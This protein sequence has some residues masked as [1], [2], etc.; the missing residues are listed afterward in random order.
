MNSVRSLIKNSFYLY[1]SQGLNFLLPFLVLPYLLTTLSVESFGIYSFAFAFSQFCLLFVDFGFNIS[2]T[3]KIVEKENDTNFIVNYFWTIISIKFIFFLISLLIGIIICLTIPSLKIYN[4]AVFYSFLMV[5]GTVFTPLW[6]FQG[7]NNFRVLTIIS[8]ISKVLTYPFI[9]LIV[10]KNNDYIN[11]I[12]IQSLSYF[13]AAILSFLYL[14][15]YKREYFHKIYFSK[16][17]NIYRLEIKESFPIFLSNSSISLYTNSIVILLGVFG[18]TYS[19]GI[20]SAVERVVRVI[21]AAVIIPLNQACFPFLIKVKKENLA[22]AKK[23]FKW[24]LFCTIIG[25][26]IIFLIYYL[27]RDF[28]ILNFFNEYKSK[29]YL[30]DIFLF[31]LLPIAIGSI[32]GQLGLLALGNHL[33]KKLFS[34]VYIYIGLFS[35]PFSFILIK[36]YYEIGAFISVFIIEI[37]VTI[38]MMLIVFKRKII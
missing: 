7:T 16:I 8:V 13:V 23:V 29:A 36:Y 24:I 33:E 6:W 35:F 21:C 4:K 37:M 22:Y 26:I 10:I 12:L 15:F 30:L 5:I 9:F 3:K 25:I 32:F 1:I 2:A 17:K 19:V 28:F 27:L 31:S 20:F 38:V 11:A 18:G 34:K 14:F